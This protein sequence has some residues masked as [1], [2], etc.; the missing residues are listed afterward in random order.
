MLAS[1]YPVLADGSTLVDTR[2]GAWRLR[3]HDAFIVRY[4]AEV[5]GSFSLPEHRDTSSMSFTVALNRRCNTDGVDGAGRGDFVGGGTWFEALGPTG[6]VVDADIGCACAF[7]GPLRHAGYPISRGTRYILV[8]FCY[9]EGFPY[10]DLVN[11]Y[12]ARHGCDR[13]GVKTTDA[14]MQRMA[15]ERLT[16]MEDATYVPLG[17]STHYALASE[18]RTSVGKTRDSVREAH[19]ERDKKTNDIAS[20]PGEL[21]TSAAAAN[22]PRPSGDSQGGYVIYQQTTALV[23]MLNRKVVSVL[24]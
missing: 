16:L 24:E 12:V 22:T 19:C 1:A 21:E 20:A 11:N 4:D 5:D 18:I 14:E 6:M 9:V 7:A 2:T 15:A 13:L 17:W 23:N 3:L 10:G 8:L